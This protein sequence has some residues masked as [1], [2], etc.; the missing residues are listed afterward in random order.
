MLGAAEGGWQCVCGGSL[1]QSLYLYVCSEISIIKKA[2]FFFKK[3]FL[4]WGGDVTQ[5]VANVRS[6]DVETRMSG[7]LSL[8]LILYSENL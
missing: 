4:F 6:A 5:D 3:R 1:H 2:I 7:C 8:L